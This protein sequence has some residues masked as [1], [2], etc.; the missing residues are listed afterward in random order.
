M[1]LPGNT[2][3]GSCAIPVEPGLLVESELPWLARLEEKWWRLITPAKPL[4][5]ETPETS[6][7]CPTLKMS[8]PTL[9]PSLKFASSLSGTRNSR[10]TCPASVE[11]L[12]R[13]PAAALLMR[14]ARRLP[15]VTCTAPYPSVAGV[16]ICV[17]RLS[18]TSSTVTGSES[19][20]SVKTRVMPTLRPTNPNVMFLPSIQGP[21]SIVRQPWFSKLDFDVHPGRQIELHQRIDRLRSEERRVGKECRSRW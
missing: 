18:D 3:P 7:I 15:K 17:T 5:C 8:T 20:S 6:T 11:A 16:L 13:W 12:A 2:R 9:P 19:P 21:D 14:D 4:P 1:R 10:K